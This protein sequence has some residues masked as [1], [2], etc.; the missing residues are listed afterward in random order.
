MLDY[1]HIL[2]QKITIMKEYKF[3]VSRTDNIG[4]VVL[5][6][7]L[8]GVLKKEFPNCKIAFI[9]K[10]YTKEISEINQHI[11][12]FI[13]YSELE[14]LN[15]EEITNKLASFNADAIIHVYPNKTLAKAALKAKIPQ[16]IGTS[17]RLFHLLTCNKLVRFTRK[18]SNLHEAVL[19]LKLLSPLLPGKT[20]PEEK[21]L[22]QFYGIENKFQ[23]PHDKKR[24]IFHTK[25]FGSAVDWKMDNYIKLAKKLDPNLC[26]IYF[27]GT[28]KESPLISPYIKEL[29]E[30]GIASDMTGKFNLNDFIKFI[31][32]CDA[33]V[34]C[35]TGPLHIASSLGITA[36]GLYSSHRPIDP[37]RWAP[38]GKQ[39]HYI[40][41]NDGK[42]PGPSI[43]EVSS[44]EVFQK[45][46]TL[47][48]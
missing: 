25:S 18:K 19:N 23:E 36:L 46:K 20:M 12:E 13:N 33:L 31:G 7:P 42:L 32:S 37:G 2:A 14:K 40:V 48:F 26:H 44:E 17:H 35:S 11:D 45:L 41:A 30:M 39:A 4:D 34:A 5:T 24:I 9:G 27:S 6:F 16:R 38:I 8:L 29:V 3:I 22:Y 43:N 28:E 1:R 15:L 21:E 47:I 10:N